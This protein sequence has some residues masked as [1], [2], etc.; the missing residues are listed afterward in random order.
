MCEIA[1]LGGGGRKKSR[2][3]IHL[4]K[5]REL[6]E[7]HKKSPSLSAIFFTWDFF[8]TWGSSIRRAVP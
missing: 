1:A 8:F 2:E 5:T 6:P 3:Y 7:E 4:K